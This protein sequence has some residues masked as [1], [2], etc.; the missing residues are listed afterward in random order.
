[1]KINGY[2]PITDGRINLYRRDGG[3]HTFRV[4]DVRFFQEESDDRVYAAH[5]NPN[6]GYMV[7]TVGGIGENEPG[8]IPISKK[9]RARIMKDFPVAAAVE[10]NFPIG[11]PVLTERVE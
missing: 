4:E 1:M 3:I 11:R 10:V 9:D 8:L 6:G 5:K 7:S 2:S